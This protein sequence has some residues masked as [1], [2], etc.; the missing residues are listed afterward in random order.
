MQ[1]DDLTPEQQH[2]AAYLANLDPE[3]IINAVA[4]HFNAVEAIHL[5][6][7][8]YLAAKIRTLFESLPAFQAYTKAHPE[9]RDY[10]ARLESYLIQKD[11]VRGGSI[12]LRAPVSKDDI[13][14]DQR[15]DIH[16]KDGSESGLL[17]RA[18]LDEVGVP[19]TIENKVVRFKKH[20]LPLAL[21]GFMYIGFEI[22]KT[23][24][25]DGK[26]FDFAIECQVCGLVPSTQ[27]CS[28]CLVPLCGLSCQK[29]L[30]GSNK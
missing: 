14:V 16:F 18:A 27:S 29:R 2:D 25:G 26:P 8:I 17:A 9:M 19:Y 11:L 24:R 21:Y 20:L 13:F 1:W 30:H 4:T 10:Q 6:R 5:S 3:A 28:C 12:I 23:D 15:G 7:S 22:T